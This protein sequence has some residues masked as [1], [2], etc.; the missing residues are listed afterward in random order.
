[1]SFQSDRDK[2]LK[3]LL[4]K[5]KKRLPKLKVLLQEMSSDWGYEDPVYRFYHHSFKVYHI[6]QMTEKVVKELRALAPHLELNQYFETIFAEGTGKKFDL[7]HNK[8][9]LKQTRPLLEAFFHAKYMLEMVCKY[10]AELDEVPQILPSGWAAVL[11]LYNL[12]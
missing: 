4:K 1:M 6:Q 5:A 2:E 11:H 9:W 7:S 12:R 10:A 3:S 8:N